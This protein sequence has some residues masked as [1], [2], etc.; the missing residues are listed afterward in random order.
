MP[1]KAH[2][3]YRVLGLPSQSAGF[4]PLLSGAG[5]LPDS[6]SV[7]NFR[8]ARRRTHDLALR[9][10]RRLRPLDDILAMGQ[11]SYYLEPSA[12]CARSA[13]GFSSTFR[14]LASAEDLLSGSHLVLRRPPAHAHPTHALVRVLQGYTQA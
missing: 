14:L 5:N 10:K 13:G 12:F 6:R 1:G 11:V 2:L 7:P 4:P 9:S 8:L 3:L